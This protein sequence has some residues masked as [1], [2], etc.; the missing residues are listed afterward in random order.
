V[1]ASPTPQR[2]GPARRPGVPASVVLLS[3]LG[4]VEGRMMACLH[5]LRSAG[6]QL[7]AEPRSRMRSSHGH[8][9][10]WWLSSRF[11]RRCRLMLWCG[12]ERRRGMRSTMWRSRLRPVAWCCA[13][14][15]R[16][17]P[18][19]YRQESS[20]RC[21]RPGRCPVSDWRARSACHARPGRAGHRHRRPRP[22]DGALRSRHGN[23]S[24]SNAAARHC[25]RA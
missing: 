13:K 22:E 18:W 24:H 2:L 9:R 20:G 23:I 17:D 6:L 21:H 7:R 16:S 1:R 10:R 4:A 14:R 19:P 11:Q 25:V 15:R 8:V 5:A 3:Q 12:S